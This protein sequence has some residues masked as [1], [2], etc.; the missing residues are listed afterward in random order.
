VNTRLV[1][2]TLISICALLAAAAFAQT[3]AQPGAMSA[4]T[5]RPA[6]ESGPKPPA[7]AT[8]GDTAWF[9][10]TQL[11]NN[12]RVGAMAPQVTSART[13]VTAAGSVIILA[14]GKVVH[15]TLAQI[16]PPAPG[17]VYER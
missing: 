11:A 14:D 1:K 5:A 8:V 6:A 10:A 7:A 13:M 3:P 2:P 17:F 4:A 12:A 16:Q 9:P 15:A